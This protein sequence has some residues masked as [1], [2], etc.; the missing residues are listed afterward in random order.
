MYRINSVSKQLVPLQVVDNGKLRAVNLLPGNF[1]FSDKIT[2]QLSNLQLNGMI[3]IHEVQSRPATNSATTKVSNGIV[4]NETEKSS[5]TP[6]SKVTPTN[7]E[8][9]NTTSK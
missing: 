3:R 8:K 1:V 2:D 4:N 6:G 9:E 7:T 5:K